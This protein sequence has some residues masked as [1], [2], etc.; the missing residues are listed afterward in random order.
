MEAKYGLCANADDYVTE[1]IFDALQ[2]GC[3]PIYL[4]SSSIHEYLPMPN[5]T[6]LYRDAQQV[7]DEILRL[8]AD[9]AEYDLRVSGSSILNISTLAF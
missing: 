2:A 9:P 4:G 3:L 5:A 6:L 8:I 1:K 7:S